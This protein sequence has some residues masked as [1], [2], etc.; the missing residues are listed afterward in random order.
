MFSRC[1]KQ[2]AQFKWCQR[3][4][5]KWMNG[6]RW[7]RRCWCCLLAVVSSRHPRVGQSELELAA[8]LEQ[9]FV[10]RACLVARFNAMS[11]SQHRWLERKPELWKPTQGIYLGALWV[12]S[13]GNK[14]PTPVFSSAATLAQAFSANL[15]ICLQKCFKAKLIIHLQHWRCF[16]AKWW[17][18]FVNVPLTSTV[19]RISLINVVK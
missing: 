13:W 10:S 3:R 2:D 15:Q 18:E 17:N 5:E 6:D 16:T 12:T 4:H 1:K 8:F 11:C 19:N 9:R 14:L 7:R